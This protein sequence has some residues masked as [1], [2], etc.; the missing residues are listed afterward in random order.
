MRMTSM[1]VL[2]SDDAWRQVHR[3]VLRHFECCKCS[4]RVGKPLALLPANRRTE[5]SSQIAMGISPRERVLGS[6]NSPTRP[7]KKTG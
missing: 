6:D 5:N 1:P 2:T 7:E 3:L 4:Q